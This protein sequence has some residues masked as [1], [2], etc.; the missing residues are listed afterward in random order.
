MSLKR[1]YQT[2][3]GGTVL[4]EICGGEARTS[5]LATRQHMMHG[6]SFDIGWLRLAK[7]R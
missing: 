1:V 2:M 6:P 7:E 5:R 4:A 3:T